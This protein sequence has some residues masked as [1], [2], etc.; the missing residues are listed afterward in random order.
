MRWYMNISI[1][2][3]SSGGGGRLAPLLGLE[4]VVVHRVR[5]QTAKHMHP[6]INMCNVV[7][8]YMMLCSVCAAYASAQKCTDNSEYSSR[9]P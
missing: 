1:A 4:F 9:A 8:P 6:Y 2:H 5:W 7:Y 3:S